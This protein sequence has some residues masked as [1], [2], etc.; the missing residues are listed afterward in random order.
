MKIPSDKISGQLQTDTVGK[1]IFSFD[2]VGSTNEVAFELASKGAPEGTVVIA[3]SQSKGRGR[4]KRK[5][6]S[7]PGENLYMSVIFRPSISSRES[8]I[9]TLVAAVA[10]TETL[11]KQGSD[12]EVKWPNDILINKRKI[13]GILSQMQSTGEDVDFVVV[14]IG[15]N[16]N[17][18]R[19]EIEN[20]M[21]GEV[22]EIATSL[23]EALGHEVDRVKLIAN[24]IEQIELWYKKLLRDGTS[25][26]IK[27]W[28]ERW[29]AVN[30]KVLVKCNG[31]TIQGIATGVDENGH[32]IVEKDDGRTEK[33]VAGDVIL[34]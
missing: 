28:M 20:E 33:V 22:A 30:S 7:P 4:L 9:M 31:E 23:Q 13:A 10:L 18:T 25:V 14:G 1:T 26:V 34:I 5:W 11:N 3:D 17:M 16:L 12:A 29:R 15:A 32:L 24:L 21:G 8:P 19:E 27:G 2:E 6:I